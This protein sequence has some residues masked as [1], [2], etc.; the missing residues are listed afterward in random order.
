VG[1]HRVSLARFRL[2]AS[3]VYAMTGAVR[4]LAICPLPHWA[5]TNRPHEYDILRLRLISDMNA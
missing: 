4:K 5:M 1:S 2:E 3:H